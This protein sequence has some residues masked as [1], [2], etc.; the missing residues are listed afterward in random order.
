M[1]WE[2]LGSQQRKILESKE[3]INL[4]ER[5]KYP[6]TNLHSDAGGPTTFN[7]MFMPEKANTCTA[8]SVV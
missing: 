4:V 6:E 1:S 7:L 3:D 2:V 5:L 8:T